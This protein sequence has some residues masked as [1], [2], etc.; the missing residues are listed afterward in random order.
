MK[1]KKISLMLLISVIAICMIALIGITAFGGQLLQVASAT[2][3]E[4]EEPNYDEYTDSDTLL[5][6]SYT[7][8]DYV[9]TLHHSTVS[10]NGSR[11]TVNDDDPIVQ[12]VPKDLF[13]DEGE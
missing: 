12:I 9:N 8:R 2:D 11:Y 1:T 3:E 7:I 10:W 4:V 6:R 5:N 13:K